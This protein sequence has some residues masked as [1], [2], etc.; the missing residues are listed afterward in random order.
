M[1]YIGTQKISKLN[2]G[3]QALSKV[4]IG[5]QL[6]FSATEPQPEEA[7]DFYFVNDMIARKPLTTTIENPVFLGQNVI[8]ST[9]L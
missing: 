4:Y 5:T 2:I 9:V 7:K 6:V 8:D 1:I 3:S